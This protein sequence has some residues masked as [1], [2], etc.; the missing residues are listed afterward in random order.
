MKILHY[1]HGLPPVR[2]GGLLVYALDL[3]EGEQRMGNEVHLLVPGKFTTRFEKRTR[4]H[5]KNWEKFSCHYII[6]PLPVTE[7]AGISGVECLAESGDINVYINFLQK[8]S[9]DIIHM[10]SLMGIHLAFFQAAKKLSIPILFTSHDYYGLC[11]KISLLRNGKMCDRNNWTMCAQ[12]ME[13][14]V[15]QKKVKWKHSDIYYKIKKN[16]FYHW[17]EY[18]K[19]LLPIKKY[20]KSII[21]KDKGENNQVKTEG[22]QGYNALFA[23][24]RQIYEHIT[25]YPFNSNQSREVY[26]SFLGEIRGQVIPITNKRVR[27]N[28]RIYTFKD[29]KLRIG[30]LSSKQIFKGYPYLEEA[31]EAMYKKGMTGFECHIYFNPQNVH[32]PYI[33]SHAQYRENDMDA[34][35]KGMDVLV[36][37]SICKETF[38]MI[39]L[40]ALSYGIPVIISSYV[41]AKELLE[42]N[43]GMGIVIEVENLKEGLRTEL[44]R[45]YDDRRI[46]SRMNRKIC[47][48]D[49]EWDFDKHVIKMIDLYHEISQ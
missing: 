17:M 19:I 15:S 48:W 37:P 28:R 4:I 43:Q 44:E 18:S 30:Y 31:L 22:V 49:R 26:E 10:H 21:K 11:P 2:G 20:I 29:D 1:I 46:L 23:Y 25:Y 40:E 13:H 41:G 6:N 45:I 42:E 32:C 38:G 35:F 33:C 9:P 47:D 14:I 7:G 36:M 27:D 12:C 39:V 16:K 24:Y 8:I 5:S 3:A 34:V